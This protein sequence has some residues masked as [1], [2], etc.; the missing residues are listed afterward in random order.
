MYESMNEF[1]ELNLE[2]YYEPIQWYNTFYQKASTEHWRNINHIRKL[3]VPILFKFLL[4]SWA[5]FSL[6]LPLKSSNNCMATKLAKRITEGWNTI[7][8]ITRY[9]C[10]GSLFYLSKHESPYP[11]NRWLM[12]NSFGCLKDYLQSTWTISDRK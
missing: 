9:I 11:E 3:I 5:S 8:Q 7:M 4:V 2:R 12:F 6:F 1:E 10:F